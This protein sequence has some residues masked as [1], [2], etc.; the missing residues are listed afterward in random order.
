MAEVTKLRETFDKIPRGVPRGVL[1][2]LGILLAVGVL[3]FLLGIYGE[4]PIRAWQIYLVNFLFWVGLAQAG[5]V[6]AAIHDLSRARWGSVIRRI[7]EGMG[8]FLP[9]AFL[10]FFPLF[11]GRHWLF[12]WVREPIPEKA[13]WLNVPFFFLRN[14]LGLLLLIVLSL[15]FLYY[16][17]RLQVGLGL[18]R[19]V[20]NSTPFYGWLARGWRGFDDEERRCR[21]YLQALS[22]GIIV[23]YAFIFSL[24]GFDLIMSLDPHWYSTLFG[25]Y[26]FMS[27]FY[28]GLAGIATLTILLQRSLRLEAQ[29]TPTHFHD[30]GKLL[31][32]FD[33]LIVGF[34][35]CQFV[36][37]WYGNITEETQYVILRTET[38][39]WALF[40]WISLIA[41]FMAPLVV[42]ISRRMKQ[43]PFALLPMGL[44]I[45]V[46]LWVERYTMVVPALWKHPAAP[47]GPLELL[48][49]LGFA[50][51]ATLSYLAFI[52]VFPILPW[53]HHGISEPKSH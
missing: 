51:A 44:V 14:G 26:F 22:P 35:W 1:V 8:S 24:M 32:G 53:P 38:L 37:I 21:Y 48:I 18:E 11:F 9:I 41:A 28:L 16:N 40:S 42:F 36:V 47:F 45:A 5:V 50:S 4:E 25:A 6:F 46:G 43:D 10:L 52:R 27:S 20:V 33:M 49:T 23:A 34:L 17:L 13:A 29:I 12:P 30:L 2:T 39:P 15:L 7:A 19:A 31:F 3:T